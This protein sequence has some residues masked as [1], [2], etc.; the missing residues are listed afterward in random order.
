MITTSIIPASTAGSQELLINITEKLCRQYC[1]NEAN[2]PVVTATFAQGEVTVLNG[3]AIVPVTVTITAIHPLHDG[4]CISPEVYTEHFEVAFNA[5]AT[6]VPTLTAG[7][8]F[9]VTPAYVVGCKAK[10]FHLTTSLTIAL[11]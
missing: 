4:R 3:N 6:N 8:D 7:T 5:T 10:G 2:K 9:L 11:A 1:V